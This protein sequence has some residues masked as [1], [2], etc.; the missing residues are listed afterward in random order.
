VLPS[1]WEALPIG[2]LEALACGVPQVATDVGGNGEAVADGRT[3]RLVPFDSGELGAAVVELLRDEPLRRTL[4][5]A[6]RARR[7]ELFTV[8]RMVAETAGVY[9]AVVGR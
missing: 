1:Q 6:S 2:L 9:A 8:E 5:T 7:D 4:A 3:G